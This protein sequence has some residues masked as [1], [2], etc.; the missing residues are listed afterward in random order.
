M[1]T[2]ALAACGATLALLLLV[3]LQP[4][5]VSLLAPRGSVRAGLTAGWARPP[6]WP[7]RFAARQGRVQM[8]SEALPAG[9]PAGV[10]PG[11]GPAPSWADA[12]AWARGE[13]KPAGMAPGPW[14]TTWRAV[15][16]EDRQLGV[17]SVKSTTP[18]MPGNIF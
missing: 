2:A 18:N 3:A 5:A 10:N 12:T 13:I 4:R 9:V 7:S 6:A 15:K 14:K 8:L 11:N 16:D 1:L 17:S